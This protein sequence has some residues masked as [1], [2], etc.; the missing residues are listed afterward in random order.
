[1]DMG[2]VGRLMGEKMDDEGDYVFEEEDDEECE[3]ETESRGLVLGV[4]F[5]HGWQAPGRDEN[6]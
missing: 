5:S 6:R 4:V 1:M 2:I 3:K